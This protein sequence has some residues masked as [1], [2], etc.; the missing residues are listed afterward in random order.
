MRSITETTTGHNADG[1]YRYIK[2]AI[3]YSL[4]NILE[5]ENRKLVRARILGYLL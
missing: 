4:R 2:T 1:G 5:E 3:I